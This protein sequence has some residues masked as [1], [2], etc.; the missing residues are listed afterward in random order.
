M[1]DDDQY[2][3]KRWILVMVGIFFGAGIGIG[4][5][6]MALVGALTGCDLV[7][8]DTDGCAPEALRCAGPRLEV[9]DA[10]RNWGLVA[11]CATVTP[12][13]W[14]CCPAQETCV[15]AAACGGDAGDHFADAGKMVDA[16]P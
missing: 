4:I 15:P 11:D 7:K 10:D 9:C 13:L 6:V 1:K 8:K 16:G 12:G 3:S 14:V 2:I 5:L